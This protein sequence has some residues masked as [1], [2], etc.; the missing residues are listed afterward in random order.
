MSEFDFEPVRGL[1]ASLPEGETL[2]WQ[3]HPDWR[4]LALRAFHVGHVAVYFAALAAWAVG[5]S[6]AAG[7]GWAGAFAAAAWVPAMAAAA[8][9]LLGLLAW[10]SARTTVYTITN[11][12][13]VLRIGIALPIIINVPFRAVESVG[14][15]RHRDGTGDLPAT[16]SKGYRLAF[17][18]LWPH[19]RP[20]FVRNPQP[21]LRCIPEPERVGRLLADAISA[22][23]SRPAVRA[24]EA[25]K[26][27][28]AS[29][30]PATSGSMPA[31]VA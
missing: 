9:A 23:P 16:L 15:R 14:L 17:L 18:V 12:R 19:A 30:R 1:P 26:P 27:V 24:A 20:W 5:S 22:A 4:G 13:I 2:L 6:W 21:M 31:A 25:A 11:R 7:T 10:L 29:T 8:I 3:G 28:P